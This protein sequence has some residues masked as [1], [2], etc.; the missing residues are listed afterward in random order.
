M[1][2]QYTYKQKT[3][4][5]L[6]LFALLSITAYKRSFSNLI[7]V[8]KENNDLNKLSE[9][10]SNKSKNLD[11]LSKEI[12]QYDNYLGVQNIASDLVQ[13]EILNFATLHDGVSIN[14]LESIHTFDGENYK[15][16]SNQL[17]VTGNVNALL[18]LAYDFETKFNFSRAIN[19]HYYKTKK[20]NSN[21]QLHLKIVFQNYE[22]NKK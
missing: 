19:I 3:F 22:M 18:K 5:L 14:N 7:A 9:E 15:I 1:F 13:Q 20:S 16:Y 8:Y 12:A 11:K 21:E 17:D 2:E 6:V 10:I 4:A